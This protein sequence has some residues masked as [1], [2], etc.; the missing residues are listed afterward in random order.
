MKILAAPS[1]QRLCAGRTPNP[2]KVN[3]LG[4]SHVRYER[5]ERMALSLGI[6]DVISGC[7]VTNFDWS[8]VDVDPREEHQCL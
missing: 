6:D 3:E 1:R 8:F 7:N 5:F 2:L 4:Y